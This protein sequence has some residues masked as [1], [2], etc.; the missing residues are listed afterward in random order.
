MLR[1]RVAL[2]TG[3]SRGIGSATARRLAQSGASVAVNYFSSPDNALALVDEIDSSGGTALAVQADVSDSSQAEAMMERVEAEMGPID[4][5]VNNAGFVRDKL[6][7]RMSEADWNAVWRTD[8]LG[9][10]RLAR[11]IIPGMNSRRWGR[12]IN[13]ASIVG[14]AGNMG[15]AN[16][17][18]AKGSLIGLTADLAGEAAEFGVTVNCVAPGYIDTDATAAMEQQYK[19]AWLEQIPMKRWGRPEEVASVVEFLAGPGASYITGQCLIVDG[20]L[21]VGRR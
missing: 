8:Y 21:L 20:G 10:A 5:L 14:V 7:L 17:A 2:V 3:A 6:L 11:S 16:Y 12:V 15:Q 9:A 13:L 1:G 19:E 18:A 4:V